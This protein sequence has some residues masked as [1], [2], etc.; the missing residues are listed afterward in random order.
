MK[1]CNFNKYNNYS[2]T[3][4]LEECNIVYYASHRGKGG[5]NIN[6]VATAVRITHIP[7]G[8]TVKSY[9]ERLQNKNKKKALEILLKKLKEKAEIQRKE[10]DKTTRE[11][12]LK[13]SIN[14]IN[15]KEKQK[16]KDRRKKI[17]EFRKK[18]EE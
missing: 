3:Q 8:I 9:E 2:L 12:R 1:Q 14:K 7:T 16:N 18:I 6:K 17:K 4:L 11:K 15:Q 5:Q 13:K 10:Q